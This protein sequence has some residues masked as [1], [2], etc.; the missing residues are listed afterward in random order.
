MSA[1]GEPAQGIDSRLLEVIQGTQLIAD[2]IAIQSRHLDI[3]ENDIRVTLTGDAQRI[4]AVATNMHF[5]TSQLQQFAQRGA[6]LAVIISDEHLLA[7]AS[8]LGGSIVPPVPGLGLG[9]FSCDFH[10]SKSAAGAAGVQAQ[11]SASGC[12]WWLTKAEPNPSCAGAR[13]LLRTNNAKMWT[14]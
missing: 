4:G 7:T 12:Q 9:S 3:E 10:D 13:C 5:V 8:P 2:S 6:G 1:P 11:P 14:R